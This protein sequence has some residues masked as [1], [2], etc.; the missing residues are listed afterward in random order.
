M[1]PNLYRKEFWASDYE[2]DFSN[3]VNRICNRHTPKQRVVNS[4][5]WVLRNMGVK[6][7]YQFIKRK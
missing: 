5:K 3:V 1:Q 6:R 4:V 7:V 2:N